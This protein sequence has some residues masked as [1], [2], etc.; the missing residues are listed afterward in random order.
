MVFLL[1]FLR[2]ILLDTNRGILPPVDVANNAV[3]TENI[4]LLEW[5]ASCNIL[6]DH[7]GIIEG[8]ESLEGL[9]W[10]SQYYQPTGERDI[11][12]I[13]IGNN[14]ILHWL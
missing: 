4:Q 5:L 6:P 8:S 1:I 12:P 3:G 13:E 10:L 14:D 9:K 11:I 2:P 7:G